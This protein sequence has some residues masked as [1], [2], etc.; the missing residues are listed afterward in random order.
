KFR[1]DLFYR[2]NMVTLELP[3]LRDRSEDVLPLTEYFLQQFCRQAGRR[4]LKL[5]ADARKRLQQ[6]AWPGNVRELRN[7]IERVAYLCASEK[8]GPTALA[9]TARPG[10]SAAEEYG[11]LTLADATNAFQVSH[12]KKAIERA[13]GNMSDAARLLGLHRPNLYRKMRLL[14]MD[15]NAQS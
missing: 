8:F 9:F 1:E 4:V 10:A 12:I 15:V 7:L 3:P 2:L 14:D 5:S 13:G 11:N 6:H